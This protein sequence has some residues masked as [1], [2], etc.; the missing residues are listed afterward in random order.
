MSLAL[1][2]AD[3]AGVGGGA[4]AG[5]GLRLTLPP[6]VEARLRS[7]A[8][9]SQVRQALS[10]PPNVPKRR[11]CSTSRNTSSSNACEIAW[12][13]DE[14]AQAHRMGDA[15]WENDC[16]AIQWRRLQ[17]TPFTGR[18][19]FII[20]DHPRQ[21]TLSRDAKRSE[22]HAPDRRLPRHLQRLRILVAQR[23][24]GAGRTSSAPGSSCVLDRRPKPPSAA[25]WR[26]ARMIASFVWP[27]S[28]R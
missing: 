18:A 24:A 15:G 8:G 5:D 23:S 7:L 12:R 6:A 14:C 21:T 13:R 19:S 11:A 1:P 2:D 3:G 27:P 26:I 17:R 9:P 28:G 22:R 25:R 20:A 16:S 10:P 4:G